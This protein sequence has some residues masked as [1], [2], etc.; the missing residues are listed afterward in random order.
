MHLLQL[1]WSA[2]EQSSGQM[3]LA[4]L[5]HIA[6]ARTGFHPQM[7][8]FSRHAG[9]SYY[10]SRPDRGRYSRQLEE[11]LG[12]CSLVVPWLLAS[13]CSHCFLQLARCNQV[14]YLSALHQ[15]PLLSCL[16]HSTP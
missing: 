1:A 5:A 12:N 10:G 8:H 6:L 15:Q 7:M 9:V 14:A 4:F 13:L 11:V 2:L 16:V 3:E